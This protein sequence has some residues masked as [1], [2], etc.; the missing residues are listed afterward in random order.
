MKVLFGTPKGAKQFAIGGE[1]LE[2][3]RQRLPD[4]DF[5]VAQDKEQFMEELRDA[6]V[7]YA[8]SLPPEAL[9]V[10]HKL[11]WL[12]VPMAGVDAVLHED[13]VKSG[14]TVTHS[15]GTSSVCMAEQAIG[16]MIYFSRAFDIAVEQKARRVWDR[17]RIAERADRLYGTTVLIVGFG[18][19]GREIAVR[20]RCF[21]MKVVGIRRNPEA[22]AGDAYGGL[23][24]AVE[25]HGPEALRE[26]LPRADWVV[27]TVPLTRETE[28]MFGREEFAAMKPGSVLINISRGKVVDEEALIEALAVGP[29]AAAALDVFDEEPLPPESPLWGMPNVLITPHIAG[30]FRA[31]TETVVSIFMKNLERY[32]KGEPLYNVVNKELGY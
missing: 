21:G 29:M 7:V 27:L 2:K 1:L 11:R 28:R 4:V 22:G 32:V 30:T 18:S 12:H 17:T 5:V 19:V 14:V 3:M 20:A 10:A 24:G 25:I 6:E 31:Y 16:S 13:L 9:S 8:L 15:G 26:L 23:T